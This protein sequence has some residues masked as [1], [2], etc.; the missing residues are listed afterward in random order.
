MQQ[1]IFN[2]P[3]TTK[4]QSL[5]N[6]I[7]TTGYFEQV[8]KINEEELEDKILYDEMKK[9]KEGGIANKEVILSKLGI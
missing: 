6:L 7:L 2:I 9:A 4:A 8:K 3:N 1:Y 5:L